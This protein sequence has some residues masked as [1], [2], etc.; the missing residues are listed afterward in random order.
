MM[1]VE[2]GLIKIPLL[3]CIV[4]LTMMGVEIGNASTPGVDVI[5]TSQLPP[6]YTA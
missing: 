3:R 6:F 4:G 1:G 2:I 5:T